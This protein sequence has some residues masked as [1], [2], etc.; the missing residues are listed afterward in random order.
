MEWLNYHHLLYFW[1]TARLGSVHRAAEELHLSQ[2]TISS[3]L[4]SLE[5]SFG[6]TLFVRRGRNLALSDSG[7]LVYRYAEDIFA[8]GQELSAAVRGAGGD[9][10]R[11]EVRI[12]IID[13]AANSSAHF[14]LEPIFRLTDHYRLSILRGATD[15]LTSALAV[16]Q[17]EVVLS[18][19]PL[20]HATVNLQNH[21]LGTCGVRLFAA[22]GLVQRYRDGFPGSLHGAPLIVPAR[23]SALRRSLEEWFT[24]SALQPRIVAESNDAGLL[25]LLADRGIGLLAGY[26]TPAS[27]RSPRSALATVGDLAHAVQHFYAVTVKRR[28]MHPAVAAILKAG[29]NCLSAVE[30]P[31]Q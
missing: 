30:S 4:R 10:R 6:K 2:P 29:R 7:K 27:E 22:P 13:A 5:R 24:K 16:Q 8:L 3:Q 15:S 31:K 28:P 23:G 18:D 17:V 9:E 11:E 14:V 21:L 25:E 1:T 12:G 19:E 26:A 20:M